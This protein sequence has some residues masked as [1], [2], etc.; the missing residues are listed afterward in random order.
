MCTL[1][2]TKNVAKAMRK[3]TVGPKKSEGKTW[4]S[5]LSDKSKDNIDCT[6]CTTQICLPPLHFD[7]YLCYKERV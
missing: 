1:L 7:D 3:I 4:F 6:T 5:Q 2:G